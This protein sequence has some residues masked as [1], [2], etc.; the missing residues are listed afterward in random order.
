MRT[1]TQIAQTKTTAVKPAAQQQEARLYR[2][3]WR[4]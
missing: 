3:I 2:V 4:Q 1:S